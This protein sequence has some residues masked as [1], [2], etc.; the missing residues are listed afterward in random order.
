MGNLVHKDDLPEVL[1]QRHQN[2]P[3]RRGPFEQ[4]SITGIGTALA[5]FRNFVPLLAQ[6]VGETPT[7][8]AIDQEPHC[9]CTASRESCAM[10]AWAY[11]RQALKSSRVR[12]G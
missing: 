7:G 10:T 1:I 3:L 6:P 9:T 2:T 11:A 5:R 12:P 4:H 8:T